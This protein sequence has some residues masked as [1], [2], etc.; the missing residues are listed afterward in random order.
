MKLHQ[1]EVIF[2]TLET[3]KR[4]ATCYS[5]STNVLADQS[6]DFTAFWGL[7]EAQL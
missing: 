5:N 4:Q 6:V 1:I 2:R 3:K 7:I